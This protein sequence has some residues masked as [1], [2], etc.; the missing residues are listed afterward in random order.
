MPHDLQSQYL[1]IVRLNSLFRF[2][3]SIAALATVIALGFTVAQ[4]PRFEM[5]A[6]PIFV[7]D[8][9]FRQSFEFLLAGAS[10]FGFI[11]MILLIICALIWFVW[12]YRSNLLARTAGAV[13]M[14]FTPAMSVVWN[15]VPVAH[16]VMSFIVLSEV[17]RATLD[18]E[19]WKKRP[20]PFGTGAAW[21][22]IEL[23][24]LLWAI[25]TYE[26]VRAS[27]LE[28]FSIHV[29]IAALW[30]LM[31]ITSL[32][33]ANLVQEHILELQRLLIGPSLPE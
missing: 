16:Y 19:G 20:F 29:Q 30:Y 14:R 27:R 13:G 31:V 23:S 17:E 1:T 7:P 22:L 25:K 6:D 5:L 33:C 9:A 18:P 24:T 8:N 11:S 12:I 2:A 10:D 26:I 28:D 32:W 15:F 3:T 21:L 4:F